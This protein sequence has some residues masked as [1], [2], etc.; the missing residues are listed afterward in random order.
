V[1]GFI[2]LAGILNFIKKED[3]ELSCTFIS[4]FFLCKNSTAVW[5]DASSFKFYDFSIII[6]L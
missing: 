3:N 5:P 4:L 2:P 1:G 6:L